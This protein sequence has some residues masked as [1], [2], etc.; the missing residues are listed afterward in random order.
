MIEWLQW[1]FEKIGSVFSYLNTLYLLP[2]V[3]VLGVIIF[4]A[5]S[6]MIVNVFVGRGSE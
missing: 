3:S 5:I 2:N 4:F 1:F 6:T